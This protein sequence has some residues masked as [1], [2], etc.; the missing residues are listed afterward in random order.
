MPGN[1][2]IQPDGPVEPFELWCKVYEVSRIHRAVD[3]SSFHFDT[4]VEVVHVV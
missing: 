4:L 1:K 3:E 2:T